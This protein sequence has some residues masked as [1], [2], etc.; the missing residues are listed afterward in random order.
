MTENTLFNIPFPEQ[1]EEDSIAKIFL[2][3]VQELR[4]TARRQPVLSEKR[5]KLIKKALDVYGSEACFSAID[6]CKASPWHMGEN[7]QGV[8]YNDI[9]LIFR[10]ERNIERFLELAENRVVG[11]LEE[12]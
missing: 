5:R 12:N 4:P 2:Y 3:W 8:K 6:G 10:N 7:P 9:E 1:K 11:F